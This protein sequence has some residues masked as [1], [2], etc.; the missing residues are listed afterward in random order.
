LTEHVANHRE[1]DKASA[2]REIQATQNQGT[3]QQIGPQSII[4]RGDCGIQGVK[5]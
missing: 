5:V 4:H 2:D 3:Y 1:L